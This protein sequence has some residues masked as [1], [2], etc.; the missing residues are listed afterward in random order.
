MSDMTDEDVLLGAL[1]FDPADV[2]NFDEDDDP[3]SLIGDGDCCDG[4][5]EDDDA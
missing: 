1:A 2:T 5:G 4:W 3:E